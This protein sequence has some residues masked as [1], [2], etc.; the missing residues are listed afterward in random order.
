MS[1][2]HQATEIATE[3]AARLA[4]ITL[5]NGFNSDIGLNVLR[6]RRRIDDNQVPCAVL[7]EGP[8][9]P[10]SGPG[11]LPTVEVVQSYVLVAYHEC[12][13]DH[14]NDKGHELIKD[15]KRAIFSDGVTLAGQ[16][17]RVHYRGR[18]IGPRGDGVGIV[19]A[20]VE[21]DVDFVEDLTNP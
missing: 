8:D 12:D 21:I 2:F 3:L 19:S 20:T 6:G 18:D 1:T 9:T 17:R 10:S 15:L 7:I 4:T 13:P 16:V 14:P 11:K 5:A